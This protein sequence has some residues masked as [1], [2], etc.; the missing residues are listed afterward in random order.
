MNII[1]DYYII[2]KDK[3]GKV[4]K[5]SG[6][7]FTFRDAIRQIS[8]MY[9]DF[10]YPIIKVYEQNFIYLN[11]NNEEIEVKILYNSPEYVCGL[12]SDDKK[13]MEQLMQMRREWT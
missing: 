7:Y 3:F 10:K 2:H 9:S 13:I 11:E 4:L 6:P 12:R 5:M 8:F 1:K